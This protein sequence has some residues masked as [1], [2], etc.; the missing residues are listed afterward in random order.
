MI[1]R[2]GTIWNQPILSD[3]GG[4]TLLIIAQCCGK[5][6]RMKEA[7]SQGWC[8]DF[9]SKSDG[10]ERAVIEQTKPRTII[11]TQSNESNLLLV[12]KRC[13]KEACGMRHKR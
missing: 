6:L 1:R 13:K 11:E 3:Q 8:T 2:S 9:T 4:D 12:Q 5:S 7:H 10:K